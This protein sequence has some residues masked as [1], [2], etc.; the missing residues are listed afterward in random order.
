MTS[1]TPRMP[2]HWVHCLANRCCAVAV[3]SDCWRTN[4]P[5]PVG[6]KSQAA[7]LGIPVNPRSVH[8]HELGQVPFHSQYSAANTINGATNP[9]SAEAHSSLVG[10]RTSTAAHVMAT[11]KHHISGH[12]INPELHHAPVDSMVPG[13]CSVSRNPSRDFMPIRKQGKDHHPS[14]GTIPSNG[15]A[16]STHIHDGM[17]PGRVRM[18]E[19]ACIRCSN[20]AEKMMARKAGH[21]SRSTVP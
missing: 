7:P 21:E 18:P 11:T 4:H 17:L 14:S 15:V 13:A 6:T 9:M 12:T 16:M 2:A 1:A 19:S 10:R 3:I 20:Q 8:V 5:N